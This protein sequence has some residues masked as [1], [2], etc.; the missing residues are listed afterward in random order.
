MISLDSSYIFKCLIN[1][2]YRGRFSSLCKT[3]PAAEAVS[4]P[5]RNSGLAC[6]VA[7][8]NCDLDPR[9]S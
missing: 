6:I 5:E 8:A 1:S 4:T 7:F 3:A 9:R 2:R